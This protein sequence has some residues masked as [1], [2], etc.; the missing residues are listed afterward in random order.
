MNEATDTAFYDDIRAA[1]SLL[2]QNDT[3]NAVDTLQGILRVN[4]DRAE[5]FYALGLAAAQVGD[6]GRAA[7]LIEHAHE[8]DPDCKEYADVLAVVYTRIGKL[9]EGMYFAKL[10]T[11]LEPH[12][13][14]ENLVPLSLGT[15]F[16]ALSGV[17]PPHHFV[18]AMIAA[19][20]RKFAR[21]VELGGMALRVDS[22]RGDCHALV[23]RC[24]GELG[25]H[26]RA[27][28]AF[29]SA[30]HLDPHVASH[31]IGLGN[32]LCHLGQFEEAWECHARALA[33]DAAS[34]EAAAGALQG[35]RFAAAAWW[36]DRDDLENE[37]QRRLRAHPA[38]A[39]PEL[40]QSVPPPA[41]DKFRI[42]YVGNRFH[43][44]PDA[45][46]FV[47]LIAS[48]DRNRVEVYCYQQSVTQHDIVLDLQLRVDGWR[49]IYDLDPEVV[50]SIIRSDGIDALVDLGGY[51]EG[52][53][54]L[55][56]AI[57]PAPIQVGWLNHLDGTGSETINLILSDPVTLE[58]DQ[59]RRRPGQEC[60][61][62]STGLFAL[63]P[64][65]LMPAVGEL[66]G[67]SSGSV[68]FGGRADLARVTPELARVWS[69]ILDAVPRS[70]LLLGGVR[71]RA[72]EARARLVDMFAHFGVSDRVF[73]HDGDP[74]LLVDPDFFAAIDVMLDT[75]PVAG[76]EETCQALWM[77]V[78]VVTLKGDRRCAQLGASILRSAGRAGWV[79]ATAAEYASLA[80][81]L[82]ADLG[83]LADVRAQLRTSLESSDLFNP[84]AFVRSLEH[85]L[86]LVLR[87]KKEA[88]A[89]QPG[90]AAAGQPKAATAR[91]KAAPA[92]KGKA[93]APRVA[94]A[95]GKPKSDPRKRRRR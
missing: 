82:A 9:T 32:S 10:A 91:K 70:N 34:I 67:R 73:F 78:P 13:V 50:A 58:T 68:T 41:T 36:R 87:S 76:T 20:Q 92:A 89:A 65:F 35:R 7:T 27:A 43:E 74:E 55:A 15:Y 85:G 69:D 95:K 30:I 45:A 12:A 80:A 54:I 22:K 56:L 61:G 48:H 47:P 53:P 33:V 40:L 42:G 19:N 1:L 6:T 31:Y 81:K 28:A 37:L 23:G 8:L 79:A 51:T 86:A 49:E 84:T 11:A 24:L 88:E 16:D 90:P 62:L 2:E 52:N 46:F 83:A 57:K 71:Y 77:G 21:A 14:I 39:S 18:H 44:G 75:F 59:A 26:G 66:P 94:G 63:E 17:E 25:E 5:P 93:K 3:M 29:H 60:L 72:D 4:P 64:Y 38:V